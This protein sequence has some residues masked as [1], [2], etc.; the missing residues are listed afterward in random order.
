[1]SKVKGSPTRASRSGKGTSRKSGN[2]PSRTGSQNNVNSIGW[3]VA[4]WLILLG[5]IVF[6]AFA[7]YD[8]IMYAQYAGSLSQMEGIWG[9]LG[10]TGGIGAFIVTPVTMTIIAVV[11]FV[12]AYFLHKK[13]RG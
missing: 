10:W 12:I 4:Y 6:A 3:I 7:V 11:L 9:I 8:W 1:M 2:A 13:L 5:A